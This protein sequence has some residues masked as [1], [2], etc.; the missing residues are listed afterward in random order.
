M[1]FP[2]TAEE[3]Y[4]RRDDRTN[5]C[6]ASIAY[7]AT[8]CAVYVSEASVATPAGQTMIVAAANLL[9]RWCRRV[10]LVLPP[11]SAFSSLGI[12]VGDLGS[13][14][15]VQ[16]KD[17]D[18]F[19]DFHV[20][21]HEASSPDVAL[22]IGGGAIPN[23][24]A[25]TVF[26]DASAWLAGISCRE[27]LALPPSETDNRLG[28]IAAACLGVAQVFKI[29]CGMSTA[30]LIRGGVFDLFRLN[31]SSTLEH[32]PWPTSLDIGR[33]LMVGGGS[34][35]SSAAY[36]I[37]LGGLVGAL[38]TVD[39]DVVKIEN[40]N[41]SPIFGRGT[42]GLSKAEAVTGHMVGSSI[43]GSAIPEWWDGFI[44]QRARS[45]LDFDVWL[46]LANEFNVRLAMQNHVPPLMI[47]ASTTAT[48]GVNHGR[49]VPGRDDCL[50]DRFPSEV[51]AHALTCSTG[52]IEDG[53]GG[54]D[55]ALP[56]ASIF[57]GL[58]VA[59]DLVRAQMP[60]YPQVPNFGHFDWYGPM[61]VLQVW[62]KMPR[63]G[64]ICRE[65][66]QSFHDHFNGE[67]RYRSLFRFPTP[68]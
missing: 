48:W 23:T 10:T 29:A 32:G 39:G 8:S 40:F 45:S 15:L 51:S 28:A 22:C 38:S 49:H 36:C 59:T 1:N 33:V 53:G 2:D 3:F 4:A 16:M 47:H 54:I 46:P 63:E 64:C 5:R 37:R 27:P 25:A 42:F 57:A 61:D 35:G 67:T 7:Q 20:G 19:G 24:E 21:V 66:G 43:R 26:I 56:F 44:S 18:P 58:L 68:K 17:A 12:G 34:V 62:N 6:C 55:A 65:Q 31:W 30:N 14:I 11:V 52:K 9:S 13:L 41:R 60:D 50:A